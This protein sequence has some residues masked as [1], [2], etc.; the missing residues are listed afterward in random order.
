VTP[1]KTITSAS[2][3][4][5]SAPAE[6][7]TDEVGDLEDSGRWKLCARMTA[8]RSRFSRWISATVAAMRSQASGV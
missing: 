3:A 5:A 4:V 7:V 1:Q 6:R 2:T 8:R